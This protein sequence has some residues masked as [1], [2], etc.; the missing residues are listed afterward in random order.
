[1]ELIGFVLILALVFCAGW[2]TGNIF[3]FVLDISE[4]RVLE[5]EA[6]DEALIKYK[7]GRESE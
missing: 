2:V 3:E 5:K 6:A 1:M 4:R 7:K